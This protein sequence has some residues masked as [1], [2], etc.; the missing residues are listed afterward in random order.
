MHHLAPEHRPLMPQS[1]RADV[2][3]RGLP[4]PGD[5]ARACMYQ[6]EAESSKGA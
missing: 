2:R 5:Q 4:L 6:A 3:I 1:D